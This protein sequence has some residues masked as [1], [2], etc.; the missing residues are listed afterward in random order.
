MGGHPFGDLAGLP[1]EAAMSA[2]TDPQGRVWLGYPRNRLAVIDRD[3]VN[4]YS[5]GD[6]LALGNVTAFGGS[7]SRAWIGG[8]AG[9][10]L[11]DGAHFR[12]LA[13]WRADRIGNISGIAETPQHEL[14]LN[15]GAGLIHV[16]APAIAAKLAVPTAPLRHERFDS[17]DGMVG[18]TALRPL[19]TAVLAADGRLWVSGTV[20]VSWVDTRDVFRNP[21]PPPSSDPYSPGGQ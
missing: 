9:L 7:G 10:A 16:T 1:R 14:W 6:G 17:R 19:P 11:F 13:T 4:L 18:Q 8:D 2:W 3:H 12:M 20:A 5:S 15:Q 21:V